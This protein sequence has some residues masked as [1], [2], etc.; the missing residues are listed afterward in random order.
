MSPIW[1]NP[2]ASGKA[3]FDFGIGI[4]APVYVDIISAEGQVVATMVNSVLEAGEYSLEFP[5]NLL[6]NGLY[7]VRVK[8]ADFSK[9]QQLIVN[10]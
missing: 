10:D 2:T 4:T 6:G 3:R 9:T 5:T 7:F 8:S 1:P